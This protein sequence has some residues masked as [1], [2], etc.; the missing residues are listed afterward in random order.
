MPLSQ[1]RQSNCLLFM[2]RKKKK[3]N[4]LSYAERLRI[5]REKLATEQVIVE[6]VTTKEY[7]EEKS[8]STEIAKEMVEAQRR[9][10]DMLTFVKER[11]E[12]LP[13]AAIQDSLEKDGYVVVDDFLSEEAI[14]TTIQEEGLA[15]FNEGMMETDLTR[16]GSG[17]Y[18]SNI[19][20]GEAQYAVCP[21]TIEL[22]V[23]VTKTL[24]AQLERYNL[25]S[26]NCA[27]SMR[28][29]DHSS[30]EASL[31]LVEGGELKPLPYDVITEDEVDTRTISLLYYPLSES[32]SEGGIVVEKGERL[33]SAKRDRLILMLSNSC[34]HRPQYFQGDH[35]RH[36]SYLELHLIGKI[37]RDVD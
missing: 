24:G 7:G 34:R 28:T 32:K 27:A 30:K 23:S 29:Y 25:D 13:N 17:E 4:K 21:R 19:E 10:V 36:A 20:G 18:V 31:A 8:N 3:I 35:F 5:H 11:V 22:V 1:K 2:G 26:S 16:L 9:S 14:I 12:G 6:P 37:E 15:L 33:V